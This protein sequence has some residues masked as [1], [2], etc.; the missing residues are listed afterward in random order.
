MGKKAALSGVRA[1][2]TDRIEFEFWYEGVRYRPTLERTPSE[3]NLRRSYKQLVDIKQRIKTR[4]FKFEEEFPDYRFK[5]ALSTASGSTAGENDQDKRRPETCKQVFDRFIAHCE[6]RVSKDDMAL[7]TLNG[8]REILDRVFRPEIGDDSFEAVLYSRLAEV[9][10]VHTQDCKKKTYNN[11]TSAVR[12]AFTFGYK[13]LPGRPNPAVALPSFRITTK[14]R[15]KV[16]PFTIQDA[17][18]I[19]ATSHRIH[20]HWYGNY[21]EFRFFTGLRQSEQFALQVEDCDLVNVKIDVTKAVVEQ[22]MKNRTKTNQDREIA[23]CPRALEVLRAQLAL[24]ERMIAAGLIKHN[25]VFFSAVGEPLETTYLPYNRWTEVLETLPV[26]FRKPYNAR[27][28]YTSWRLMIGHNRLLV[29]YEDGHSVATMERTYAAWTKGAK[30]ED[31]ELIK[32]AMARR[33]TTYDGDDENDRRHRRRY[34][35]KPLQSPKAATT[36]PLEAKK[37]VFRVVAHA[38]RRRC[39]RTLSSCPAKAKKPNRNWLGWQDS[40]LRMAGSKPAALPLGDTPTIH[41][42]SP[43]APVGGRSPNSQLTRA[44]AATRAPATHSALEPRNS[45]SDPARAPRGAP[46]RSR[47]HRA[48]RYRNPS[49]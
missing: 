18:S 14:D 42:I 5:G 3:A 41:P 34:R 45:S 17:E 19:I 29:A 16:D 38:F 23:L 4:T 48:R 20:G 40:N 6:L 47:W 22:E 2:G 46:R 31:V 25:F 10:A 33:P 43:G 1:K 24:R 7:S 32:Q 12:T 15:P 44:L 27:H 36:L 21:E 28:S 11:I 35:H 30:P 9:V 26:R 39:A 13:D 49:R 8:Y 37:R